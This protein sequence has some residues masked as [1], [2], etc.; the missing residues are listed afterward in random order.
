MNDSSTAA[1]LLVNRLSKVEGAKPLSAREYWNLLGLVTVTD[2]WTLMGLDTAQHS[3]AWP[4][5]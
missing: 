2:P 3:R 1:L 4:G 5:V